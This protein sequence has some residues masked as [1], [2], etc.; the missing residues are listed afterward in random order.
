[1][2]YLLKGHEKTLRSLAKGPAQKSLDLK[3]LQS[4][5]CSI[6]PIEVQK[7]IVSNIDDI[8]SKI[9]KI[10]AYTGSTDN[11]FATYRQTLIENAVRGKLKIS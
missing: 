2:Y 7:K 4:L 3:S 9:D 1:M 8:V 5:K 11:V 10:I 6:P